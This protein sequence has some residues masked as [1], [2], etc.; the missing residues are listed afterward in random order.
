MPTATDALLDFDRLPDAAN[1]DVRVVAAVIGS[2]PATVW[3]RV[4]EGVFPAPKKF[5][6]MS[7]RWNVGELRQF[8][9][10][11]NAA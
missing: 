1:V 4:K 7:T 3:R 5:G 11:L 2:H 6:P 9:A 8:L 10:S